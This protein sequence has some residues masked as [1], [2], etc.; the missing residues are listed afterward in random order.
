MLYSTTVYLNLL[1][2]NTMLQFGEG[3]GTPLQYSFA[4]KI[5]WMEE[6]G[7]LQSMGSLRVQHDWVTSLSPFI[8]MHWRR[9][10][11]PTPLLLSEE[12]QGRGGAWWA[13]VYGIAQSQ[14]RLKQLSSS[15][16]CSF[17]LGNDLVC[18]IYVLCFLH[19]FSWGSHAF[20]ILP[21]IPTGIASGD[22]WKLCWNFL[23][24]LSL[25]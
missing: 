19:I 25:F 9:K 21:F 11:Q 16:S 7:R 18:F 24:T 17:V 4:W 15:S 10:W 8:L 23:C 1:F 20:S 2:W 6:P 14:T 13:A 5:P 22:W 12:S 3:S